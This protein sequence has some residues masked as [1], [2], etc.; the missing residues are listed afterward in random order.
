[1]LLLL[2]S[3]GGLW[4]FIYFKQEDVGELVMKELRKTLRTEMKVGHVRLT[5]IQTFPY[6]SI[7]LEDVELRDLTGKMSLLSA[8]RVSCQL[9]LRR[10]LE[11]HYEI[12]GIRIEDAELILFTDKKG[13]NNWDVAIPSDSQDTTSVPL[14]LHIQKA[15]L[16]Q[17]RII[18]L[19]EKTRTEA[20][21]RINE[22]SLS[23][24]FA[25]TEFRVQSKADL[26]CGHIVH[27]RKRYLP[28]KSV[29]YDADLDI[30]LEKGNYKI[31]DFELTAEGNRFALQGWLETTDFIEGN[32]EL[33]LEGEDL[34]I[35]QMLKLLPA[36]L[37][38]DLG[39]IGSST[40]LSLQASAKGWFG[41]HALPH[42]L[43]DMTL[44]RGDL[45]HPQL[46]GKL[47]DVGFSLN[48]DSGQEPDG[49]KSVLKLKD[50][51][52]KLDH[53]PLDLVME[54]RGLKDPWILARM[55]G[56]LNVAY[57]HALLNERFTDGGGTID[58]QNIRLEGRVSELM[59]AKEGS[60]AS[61]SGGLV[62]ANIALKG[63]DGLDIKIPSGQFLFDKERI[64][65]SNFKL[66]TPWA[67]VTA[68]AEVTKFLPHLLAPDSLRHKLLPIEIKAT[69]NSASLDAGKLAAFFGKNTDQ[70]APKKTTETEAKAAAPA[71]MPSLN[72]LLKLNISEI[73]YQKVLAKG[74][75]VN[76]VF[77][78][79][80]LELKDLKTQV[81]GG[82]ITADATYVPSA[83]A[84]LS[85]TA[86]LFNID[87][88]RALREMDDFGQ[89]NLTHKQLKGKLS[90]ALS[91][92]AFW[93]EKQVLQTDKLS[94][95]A[96][97]NIKDGE[98]QQWEMLKSLST[99]VKLK[100]LERVVFS[101]IKNKFEL[102]NG[103]LFMPAMTIR[104][105]AFVLTVAGKHSLNQDM[106]Y[107]L[108][109]N[110]GQVLMN[111]FKAHNPS[112]EP[113]PD[114]K[115][116]LFNIH[117]HLFGNL[118]K[119]YDF[120]LSKSAVNQY[121]DNEEALRN[122]EFEVVEEQKLQ[123]S[124]SKKSPNKPTE[125]KEYGEKK[126]LETPIDEPEFLEFEPD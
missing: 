70:S 90:T 68:Q 58:L 54:V 40:S 84:Q 95:T 60:K 39:K 33:A 46:T 65:F 17:V 34:N 22:M 107:F 49:S 1:M 44:E 78:K 35:G 43:A 118:T 111:K 91:V 94:V 81:F 18:I 87:A 19:N 2:I 28:K 119:G 98:L 66:R 112:Y 11:G 61:L 76:V 29:Q 106:D 126:E 67:D 32:M 109:I 42:I 36:D 25:N 125:P 124:P 114:R 50:F 13:R 10:L 102:S 51:S 62:L 48:F 52:A 59:S 37:G 89:T 38:K 82:A 9:G 97:V 120:E 71:S 23:G 30:D 101:E 21:F 5:I 77:T 110:A 63:D 116:G 75:S 88:E 64:T 74:N 83:N 123:D 69:T 15:Q 14:D 24:D 27:G 92:K 80:G 41:K 96:D 115:K 8:K 4:A 100:D 122:K 73:K 12:N 121:L 57:I 79:N 20:A 72:V 6:A 85:L 45:E 99:F 16:S 47:E 113:L 31:N 53:Q 7:L 3:V 86:N 93:D 56:K 105:N 117:V 104:S 103:V 55:N 108:R 26:Y